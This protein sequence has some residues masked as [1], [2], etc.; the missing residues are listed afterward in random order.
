MQI[1]DQII[2]LIIAQQEIERGHRIASH[3]N[4]LAHTRIG[5]WLAAG[6]ILFVEIYQRRT[7]QRLILVSVVADRT[8]RLKNLLTAFLL[9]C[10]RG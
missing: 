6:Q 4:A 7:L 10:Q 5:W 8:I 9:R 1:R 3:H 2:D